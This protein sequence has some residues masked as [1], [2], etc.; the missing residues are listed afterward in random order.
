M[1]SLNDKNYTVTT[2]CR[3]CKK[4]R[5]CYNTEDKTE[6]RFLCK[7]CATQLEDLICNCRF[8]GKEMLKSLYNK[9]GGYCHKCYNDNIQE[10]GLCGKETYSHKMDNGICSK[11]LTGK[12]KQCL[13]CGIYINSKK[14]NSEGLCEKCT[15]SIYKILKDSKVNEIVECVECGR[16]I[17]SN[18]QH[19]GLCIYCYS[20]ELEK[21]INKIKSKKK[22]KVSSY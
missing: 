7:D 3:K 20:Q 12:N 2:F 9:Q 19:E 17:H 13:K 22:K 1:K 21:Q 18:D 5:S 16:E 15:I 6:Y 4:I 10:C 14:L 8:C 11:C